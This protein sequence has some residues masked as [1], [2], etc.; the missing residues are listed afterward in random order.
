M[1]KM[2]Q[3]AQTATAHV[4]ADLGYD[5]Y[6]VAFV[7]EEGE[8]YLRY[9]ILRRDDREV[10]LAD[11]ERVSR[12]LSPVLDEADP[13]DLPYFL[14]V[15]SPGIFRVLYT[16]EH[17]QS[18]LGERIRVRRIPTAKGPKN[19][20][21]FLKEVAKDHLV[22]EQGSEEISVPFA[23]VLTVNLEPEL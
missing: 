8:H 3:A 11:C 20:A 15:S 17:Y 22:L 7:E 4:I 23:E 14:E 13:I 16:K 9:T 1:E 12:A 21:G 10:T 6:H 5:L 2:A 19:Q 18:A